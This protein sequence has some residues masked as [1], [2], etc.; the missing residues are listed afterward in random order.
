M[1]FLDEVDQEISEESEIW[2]IKDWEWHKILV[3]RFTI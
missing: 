1:I 2:E 3:G